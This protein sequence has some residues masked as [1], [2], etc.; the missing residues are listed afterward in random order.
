MSYVY[1]IY[2]QSPHFQD[3][4]FSIRDMYNAIAKGEF[5]QYTMYIQV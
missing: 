3:P 1:E 5:P 4:D 2:Y